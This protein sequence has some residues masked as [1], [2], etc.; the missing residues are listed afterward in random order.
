MAVWPVSVYAVSVYEVYII[1][2]TATHLVNVQPMLL[3]N[4]FDAHVFTS[5]YR[6]FDA[7]SIQL[8]LQVHVYIE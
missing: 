3:L 8:R 4:M 5:T 2:R 1:R 7:I 6:M